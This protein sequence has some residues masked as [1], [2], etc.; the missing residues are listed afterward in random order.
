MIQRTSTFSPGLFK[1]FFTI[2]II[3]FSGLLISCSRN[4]SDP[5]KI[6]DKSI[7][8][9]GGE[10]YL[11]SEIEFDFRDRHYITKRQEGTFSKERI[12][13]DSTATIHDILTNDS[14]VRKINDEIVAIPDSMAKKYTSSVNSVIYFALLPY[15]LNDP[16]VNKKLLGVT[17]I[18]GQPYYKIEITFG[19]EGGGDGHQD[20]FNY[21]IHQKDF[22]V[23]YL[24]Y[25]Y[26]EDKISEMRFRKAINRRNV[27]GI[28]FQDY[29]NYEPKGTSWT[30]NEVE[31]IYKSSGLSEL[32]RIEL[33]NT[34]V[35]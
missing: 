2:A 30:F 35:K 10:K 23:D 17:T 1:W 24:A 3:G 32:S 7:R 29:I 5:Q 28:I 14:F 20:T 12:F 15:G 16:S 33:K 21:W 34:S 18:E 25:Y 31:E 27:D 11:H 22:T 26:L 19:R 9:H 4:F 6:I 8:V 13:K